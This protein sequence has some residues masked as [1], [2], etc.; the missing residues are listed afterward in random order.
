MAFPVNESTYHE[1]PNYVTAWVTHGL[2]EA[3]GAGY[4][5]ALASRPMVARQPPSWRDQVPGHASTPLPRAPLPCNRAPSLPCRGLAT[6]GISPVRASPFVIGFV[7][8]RGRL[9]NTALPILRRHF[10]WF[11]HASERYLFLPALG[12][13][14]QGVQAPFPDTRGQHPDPV[15]AQQFRNGHLVYATLARR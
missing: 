11:N 1:N 5:H 14:G 4:A 8:W 7:C 13:P 9:Q 15:A 3:A 2:L 10:D 6:A 12:G